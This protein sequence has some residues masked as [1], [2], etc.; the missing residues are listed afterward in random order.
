L[1]KDYFKVFLTRF[2]NLE[3]NHWFIDK[4]QFMLEN[5]LPSNISLSRVGFTDFYFIAVIFSEPSELLWVFFQTG[6]FLFANGISIRKYLNPVVN[7]DIVCH[8][9][10]KLLI[11]IIEL[12]FVD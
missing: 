6:G 2:G 8:I 9:V 10:S 11:V 3:I 7:A 5:I 12:F 1:I 4:N